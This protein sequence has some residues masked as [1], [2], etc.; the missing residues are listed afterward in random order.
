LSNTCTRN[1]ERLISYCTADSLNMLQARIALVLNILNFSV[2]FLFVCVGSEELISRGMGV[3]GLEFQCFT[4]RYN[5][6][7]VPYHPYLIV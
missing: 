6:V 3:P 5:V 7:E 4:S 1:S 2:S